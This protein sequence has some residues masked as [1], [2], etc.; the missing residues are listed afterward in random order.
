MTSVDAIRWVGIS[1]RK[2]LY[3]LGRFVHPP[4]SIY[5]PLD[6][7]FDSRKVP[8]LTLDLFRNMAN[9]FFT[10]VAVFSCSVYHFLR[11]AVTRIRKGVILE[12]NNDGRVIIAAPPLAV[13][14]IYPFRSS[15]ANDEENPVAELTRVFLDH[16]IDVGVMSLAHDGHVEARIGTVVERLSEA[17]DSGIVSVH[18]VY[19]ID[20]VVGG[21]VEQSPKDVGKQRAARVV[22]ANLKEVIVGGWRR[23]KL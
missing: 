9:S 11:G 13:L 10:A 5:R 18:R 14:V 19:G 6:I 12:A 16:V 17:A 1:E 20:I 7:K 3:G 15:V 2:V 22:L 21:V 8:E 4:K 23:V